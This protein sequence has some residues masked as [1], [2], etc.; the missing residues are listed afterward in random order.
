MTSRTSTFTP[1][2]TR[3]KA[4]VG[5]LDYVNVLCNARRRYCELGW[6]SLRLR[7]GSGLAEYLGPHESGTGP[8]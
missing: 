4:E 5:I 6:Q 7:K 8:R 2:E 3:R 1:E